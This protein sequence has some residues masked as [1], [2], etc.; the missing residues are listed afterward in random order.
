MNLFK[1]LESNDNTP[2]ENSPLAYRMRPRTLEEFVN[3]KHLLAEGKPLLRAIKADRLT[4]I[5]L[6]GPPG[7]GKTALASVISKATNSLF[8]RLNAVTSSVK[9]L[10]IV[11]ETARKRKK[12]YNQKTILFID[13]IHRFNKAQQDVLMP[14]V[15]E[16]NVIL[17]GATTH[18]PFFSINPPI[19]SRSGVFELKALRDDDILKILS[20]ALRDKE[21][22][23]GKMKI[24]VTEE[25]LKLIVRASDGDARRALNILEIGALTTL[26]DEDNL[27]HYSRQVA[28][29][30]I[31][32]KVVLY[33]KKEDGHYDTISG[34]IKSMR[35]S[36]PDAC[37]YWLAKMIYAGEDVRFIA[38]RIVICAAEDVGNADPRALIL[39][40][41]AMQAALNIGLPEARIPLAQAALY[42]SCAPKSNASYLAIESALKDVREKRLLEVPEGIKDTH[43]K[44]ARRL[45]R[46]EGYIYPHD[47]EQEALEQDYLPCKNRYYFP[48]NKGL[49]AEFK[50]LLELKEKLIKDR[51]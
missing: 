11:I 4:S 5:I 43:Y 51:V 13:E 24:K 49:E 26:P 19:I 45:K 29:D 39:A 17:I 27:I 18:N 50:E 37:V 44:G 16:G 34:F 42:I 15:E 7:T 32:R 46:G 47:K 25:A 10:R 20:T 31:G 8:C 9:E 23:L 3:Q 14:D 35:G 6:Y 1:N 21:R 30:C 33:D 48:K 12:L 28:L 38:R 22:G 40:N 2:Q 41:A 36:D